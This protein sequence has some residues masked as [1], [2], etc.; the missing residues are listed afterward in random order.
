MQNLF[1]AAALFVAVALGVSAQSPREKS[2]IELLEKGRVEQA[3]QV[4]LEALKEDPK[5][6]SVNTLLGQIAFS[7]KDYAQAVARF[8]KAPSFLANNPLL[9]VNFAEALLETKAPDAAR[10]ALEKLPAREPVA[11]FEA[12]LLLARFEQFAPAE[13]HFELAKSGYPEPQVLA[14]NIALT[15]YRAGKFVKSAATL[16]SLRKQTPQDGDVLNLLGQAYVDAG[17]TGKA[18]ATLQEATKIHPSDERN[19]LALAKLAMDAEMTA[20]GIEAMDRGLEQL[21]GSYALR[22]QRGFLRLSNGLY[23]DAA[24]DYRRAIEIQPSSASPKIGLAF[25]LLQDKREEEA[26]KILE[27]VL[28]SNQNF[29]V[30]YLLGELRVREERNDEAVDHLR[31]AA[32]IEPNFS[33]THTNLGKLYLKKNDVGAAV[34]ELELAV[35]L[36]SEDPTAYYQLSMAYRRIGEREK[37]QK[38]LAQVKELNKEQREIGTTRFLTR[39]LRKLRTGDVSP[40]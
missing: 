12:G 14:Y 28:S 27:G 11:Q 38:A 30:H 23:A 21:P 16:E 7:R 33:P 1:A 34:K 24:A 13:E 25:V 36:D 35:S 29:F 6:Q 22:I 26:A 17:D 5:S 20:M 8:Q 15:Q 9:L 10:R 3:Q 32:Q 18:Q 39:R 31:K 2:A 19:Y 40:F 37:A 4:L